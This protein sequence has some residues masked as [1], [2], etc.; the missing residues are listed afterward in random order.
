MQTIKEYISDSR[1][2]SQTDLLYEVFA[3]FIND[4]ENSGYDFDIA[5]VCKW[6][7]GQK[8]L[9]PRISRYYQEHQ[10]EDVLISDI[11]ITS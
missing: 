4:E 8:A 3:T 5:L 1:E 2:L 9:T 10:M 7:N 6:F 11:S